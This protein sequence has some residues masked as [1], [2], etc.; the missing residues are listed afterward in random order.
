MENCF[1]N[2]F[3]KMKI[4]KACGARKPKKA[5]IECLHHQ[6]LV[7]CFTLVDATQ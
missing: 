6:K 4:L 7:H 3:Q 1:A 2:E 5:I